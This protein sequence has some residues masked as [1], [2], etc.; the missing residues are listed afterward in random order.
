MLLI[1]PKI[2]DPAPSPA[3]AWVGN[4]NTELRSNLKTPKSP[5]HNPMY[6]QSPP[7]L[8]LLG[9]GKPENAM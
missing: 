5:N 7:D 4:L 1:P 6:R 8:P 3:P 9:G 2:T